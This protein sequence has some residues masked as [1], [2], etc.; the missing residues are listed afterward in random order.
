MRR[1]MR[2]SRVSLEDMKLVVGHADDEKWTFCLTCLAHLPE[3]S[4]I[5]VE[6]KSAR[7]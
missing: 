6:I 4:S 5:A 2:I 3:S 1:V 7:V